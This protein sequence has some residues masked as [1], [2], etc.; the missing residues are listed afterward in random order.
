MKKTTFVP[1]TYT[2]LEH[3]LY[4]AKNKNG[5]HMI[6]LNSKCLS[7]LK[8]LKNHLKWVDFYVQKYGL[9]LENL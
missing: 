9:E 4:T 2:S 6:F 5:M 8:G 3:V 1:R 7:A